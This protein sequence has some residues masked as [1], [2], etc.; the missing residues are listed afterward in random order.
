[1]SDETINENQLNRKN[2]IKKDIA[3]IAILIGALLLAY[4]ATNVWLSV[5]I[6]K[7]VSMQNTL[8]DGDIIWADKIASPKRGEVVIFAY[9]EDTDYVK[10]VIAVEGD[11]LYFDR[12]GD[13]YV[14]YIKYK[15]NDLKELLEEPYLSEGVITACTTNSTFVIQE[16][17]VFV[18][19]DNREESYDSR[20]FGPIKKE[21][22]KGVVHNFFIDI[23]DFTKSI[24]SS[25]CAK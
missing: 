7:N 4:F 3:I 22:I 1:M 19:G 12:K 24:Y 6:V 11:T 18:M 17:E 25:S 13:E 14:V 16:G 20:D 8:N 2:K 5:H 10:R 15:G 21:Q 23:K 9:D